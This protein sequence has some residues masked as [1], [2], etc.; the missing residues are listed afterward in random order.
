VFSLRRIGCRSRNRPQH[1]RQ[2]RRR[3]VLYLTDDPEAVAFIIGNVS[4][5]RAFEVGGGD[6]AKQRG[7]PSTLVHK[8]LFI[9]YLIFVRR[10]LVRRVGGSAPSAWRGPRYR[11]QASAGPKVFPIT[12]RSATDLLSQTRMTWHRSRRVHKVAHAVAPDPGVTICSVMGA[13]FHPQSGAA[14]RSPTDNP[15]WGCAPIPRNARWLDPYCSSGFRLAQQSG[16]WSA[17]APSTSSKARPC[18]P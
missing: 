7:A 8:L 9:R 3:T 2:R 4:R 11:P 10:R 17:A 16:A 5:I 1:W 14:R 12:G 18:F 6:C 15:Q 13:P